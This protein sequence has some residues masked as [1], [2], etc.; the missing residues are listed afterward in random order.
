[1]HTILII[2]LNYI[3]GCSSNDNNVRIGNKRTSETENDVK[4]T[5]MSKKEQEDS[6]VLQKKYN[7]QF[8]GNTVYYFTLQVSIQKYYYKTTLEYVQS[9]LQTSSLENQVQCLG[10][11]GN[12]NV[13]L[14]DVFFTQ[15]NKLWDIC[16]A[17]S[18]AV[19]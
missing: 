9:M 17:V 16:Q 18:R 10:F 1:M 13:I 11:K 4:E 12:E 14:T 2:L 7:K 15:T 5:K 3:E 8:E 19:L 6:V